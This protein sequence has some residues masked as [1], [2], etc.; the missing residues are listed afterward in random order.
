[1]TVFSEEQKRSILAKAEENYKIYLRDSAP[2]ERN[3]RFTSIMESMAI[4][5]DLEKRTNLII[6]EISNRISE[7][8][9]SMSEISD[10]TDSLEEDSLEEDSLEED[11]IRKVVKKY[12]DRALDRTPPP[13][14]IL[15]HNPQSITDQIE[16]YLDHLKESLNDA[17]EQLCIGWRES[18]HDVD[19][20]EHDE[21]NN[22]DVSLQFSCSL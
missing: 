8:E 12:F 15:N 6:Q 5:Q 9:E 14:P 1:M 13:S 3:Y 21:E 4:S 22:D 17:D 2:A 7:Q 19:K 10:I 16:T 11:D 18:D 20:I